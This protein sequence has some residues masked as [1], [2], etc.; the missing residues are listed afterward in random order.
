MKAARSCE[1]A[2]SIKHLP[3]PKTSEI[4]KQAGMEEESKQRPLARR[5]RT[6]IPV[7]TRSGWCARARTRREASAAAFTRTNSEASRRCTS[8]R[9]ARRAHVPA[10]RCFHNEQQQRV[11]AQAEE[12]FA[13]RTPERGPTSPDNNAKLRDGERQAK[14]RANKNREEEAADSKSGCALLWR[15]RQRAARTHLACMC[16]YFIMPHG[17]SST[18]RIRERGMYARIRGR[19]ER[20]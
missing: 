10:S 14:E 4:E 18:A 12:A 16:A 19:P 9:R 3:L 17:G 5:A 13:Q 7:L 6:D 20:G 15:T 1:N 8:R 2:S 11:G